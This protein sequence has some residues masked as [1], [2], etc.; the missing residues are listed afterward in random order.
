[1][2]MFSSAILWFRKWL[3]FSTHR[4]RTLY[5]KHCWTRWY[6][7]AN[8]VVSTFNIIFAESM[9]QDH[10]GRSAGNA[11]PP[12]SIL[13]CIMVLYVREVFWIIYL[14][15]FFLVCSMMGRE[16]TGV[17]SKSWWSC[18][19]LEAHSWSSLA[20]KE[21]DGKLHIISK[22]SQWYY[23][24]INIRSIHKIKDVKRITWVSMQ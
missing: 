22:T 14:L 23:V 7:W 3:W 21:W 15:D 6:S 9:S 12:C 11:F 4:L 1:M 19:K 17:C 18:T 16:T 5:M 24:R 10:D 8:H 20:G 13:T 2:G